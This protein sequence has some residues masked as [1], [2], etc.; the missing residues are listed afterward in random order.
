MNNRKEYFGRL[1]NA[2]NCR[3][4]TVPKFLFILLGYLLLFIDRI[5][6]WLKLVKPGELNFTPTSSKFITRPYPYSIKKVSALGYRP[7]V[8]L[9]EGMEIIKKWIERENPI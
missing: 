6:T 9:D 8:S 2:G 7:R 1:G 3:V 5:Q 4:A